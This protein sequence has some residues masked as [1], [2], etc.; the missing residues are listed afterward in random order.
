[1]ASLENP[2]EVGVTLAANGLASPDEVGAVASGVI[3]A[4]A[5]AE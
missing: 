5:T 2:G 4:V 3:G 1:M